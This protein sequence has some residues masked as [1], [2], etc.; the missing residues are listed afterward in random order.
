MINCTKPLY[1]KAILEEQNRY[2]NILNVESIESN[3]LEIDKSNF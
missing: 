2:S 1:L 3:T